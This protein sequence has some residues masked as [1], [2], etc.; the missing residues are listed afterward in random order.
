MNLGGNAGDGSSGAHGGRG[1][2]VKLYIKED[3]MDLLLALKQPIVQGGKGGAAGTHGTPG[4]GGQGGIGGGAFSWYHK[5]CRS[6][7]Q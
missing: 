2:E 3:D 7:H 5:F 4:L 1:G 6:L